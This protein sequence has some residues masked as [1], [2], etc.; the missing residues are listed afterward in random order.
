LIFK[1]LESNLEDNRFWC[2]NHYVTKF[3]Y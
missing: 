2:T 1:C 3:P